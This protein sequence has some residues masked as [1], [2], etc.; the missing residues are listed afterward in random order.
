[1]P[2][3]SCGMAL[4]R[5]CCRSAAERL[6]RVAECRRRLVFDPGGGSPRRRPHRTQLLDEGLVDLRVAELDAEIVRAGLAQRREAA[7]GCRPI[8]RGAVRADQLPR[9]P[10]GTRPCG[11]GRRE[12]NGT[13]SDCN[14][15]GW[16][17]PHVIRTGRRDTR[18]RGWCC[19]DAPRRSGPD[20]SMIL[21]I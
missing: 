3:N 13:P 14:T 19:P 9:R 12:P 6:E 15:G 8:S 17:K 2:P 21:S 1:M 11:R 20:L 4:K 16:Q 18:D 5:L 10:A 7:E